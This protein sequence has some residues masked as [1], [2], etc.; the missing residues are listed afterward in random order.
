M[1]ALLVGTARLAPR[2]TTRGQFV[3]PTAF[4]EEKALERATQTA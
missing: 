4:P 3:S 1:I 2:G